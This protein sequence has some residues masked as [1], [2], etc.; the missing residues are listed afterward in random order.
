ML[1][2]KSKRGTRSQAE[3]LVLAT[4]TQHAD[5]L[6]TA[7]RHSLCADDASDA[8]Q[9]ALEI[10]LR[11]AARLDPARA[12]SWLHTVVKHEAM[13]VRQSRQRIVGAEEFD[14]DAIEA[15]HQPAPDERLLAFEDVTRAAEALQGLKPQELRALWLRM[16]GRTYKEI[17]EE[18]DWTYTKVNR[19]VTEGRRAFLTRYA[20]I[21]AGVEC[22]RY[23]SALSAFVDGEL[24]RGEIGALRRHLRGCGA[25]RG[26]LRSLRSG[27]RSLGAVLPVGLAV[28]GFDGAD[29]AFG[30]FV[31]V[32]ETLVGNV[33]ERA[34]AVA[35]KTQL[36][37][38]AS[39]VMK[40][41]AVAGA[42]AAVAGGGAVT[43]AEGTPERPAAPRP[44]VREVAQQVPKAAMATCAGRRVGAGVD[45]RANRGATEKRAPRARAKARRW[46]SRSSSR[47]QRPDR[48]SPPPLRRP[49]GRAVSSTSSRDP[50]GLDGPPPD[51]SATGQGSPHEEVNGPACA[52]LDHRCLHRLRGRPRRRRRC[53]G[54]HLSDVR[55]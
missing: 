35:A 47:P 55:L 12:V 42:A 17:A 10:F 52:G 30:F 18:L 20:G 15:I 39:G 6:G 11:N 3:D 22:R 37:A 5:A 40:V 2:H 45:H 8:Y 36:V 16:E 24:H 14:G 1:T 53:E 7:R 13:A 33:Q 31:R 34:V 50:A 28:G 38:E 21:E 9:R 43:V 4:I 44:A 49:H 48:G 23:E 26:T 29:S 54:R 25:C 27:Q 19:C 46:S 51:T 41:A 32:Y